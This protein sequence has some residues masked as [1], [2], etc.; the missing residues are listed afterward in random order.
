MRQ[1][2][3]GLATGALA[4]ALCGP[5]LAEPRVTGISA[6]TEG[7][8]SK[9]MT[10]RIALSEVAPFRVA[11]PEDGTVRVEFDGA[12][13]APDLRLEPDAYLQRY[14]ASAPDD[15]TL[16]L[17]I[18]INRAAE[19]EQARIDRSG[20][21]PALV[22]TLALARS[23][24]TPG[25]A[26]QVAAADALPVI[27]LD[28]GHGG[29]DPGAIRD[30]VAEKEIALTF[31]LELA[32]A[33]RAT[34]RYEVYLTRETD[35]FL[36]LRER[37]R[38]ARSHGAALFLSLH[39]NTVTEGN[40]SGAAVYTL[41]ARASD[42]EAA[43]LAALENRADAV[44]GAQLAVED[45]DLAALLTDM[46]QR[47]TN[48]RSV[49]LAE[50]LVEGLGSSVGVIRSNPHRAAGFRVL[51]APDVPSVLVELGFLS[52]SEDLANMTSPIWRGHAADGVIAAVD[53]WASRDRVL[54]PQLAATSVPLRD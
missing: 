46:A 26:P 12:E 49:H 36:T 1:I 20:A 47:E 6:D 38:T 42:R 43:A 52:D 54:A 34:G 29:V 24:V 23:T 15:E 30:G 40:A 33:L 3:K 17:D 7:W 8:L 14:R 22:L 10:L 41:S 28:P 16:R 18:G 32:E 11:L 37:V 51:K 39:A 4:L 48:L 27:V 53:A 19:L 45:D 44:G 13:A 21:A 5:V 9:T 25:A 35:T 31:G 2:L 50:A